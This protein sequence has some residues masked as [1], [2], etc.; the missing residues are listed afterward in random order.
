[1]PQI[2]ESDDGKEIEVFTQEEVKAQAETAVAAAKAEADTV[3]KAKE[4]EIE[5]FKKVSAEK[6][7]NF[8]KYNE[9]TEEE[10]KAHS[11]NEI[12][13]I[14]RGDK[15]EEEL[16]N[17]KKSLEDKETKEKE[18][19]KTSVLKGYHGDK[20]D[21]KKSL[22]EKYSM[23]AGMPESTPDEIKARANAA[24]TLAGISIDSRNPLYSSFSGEAPQYKEKTDYVESAEGKVA[25][26]LV[27]QSMGLKT[28]NK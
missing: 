2:I 18:Y 15:L 27:R 26:D 7:E 22:E 10:R 25:A 24:A 19:T 13:Q 14:R 9:M 3:I 8:R 11:E 4:E 28:D 23:L 1:M 12:I 5:K 20:E 21:I 17:V 6:T 16:G